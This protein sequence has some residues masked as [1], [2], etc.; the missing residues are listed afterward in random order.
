MPG[1]GLARLGTAGAAGVVRL[2]RARQ[3]VVRPGEARPGVARQAWRVRSGLARLGG[4]WSGVAGVARHVTVRR[5][6]VRRG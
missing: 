5:D 6:E 4:L 1:F 2:G 3:G